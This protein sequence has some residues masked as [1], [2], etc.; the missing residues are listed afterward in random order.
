MSCRIRSVLCEISHD[1][2]TSQYDSAIMLKK[3]EF[4]PKNGTYQL[5]YPE[6]MAP[7]QAQKG[8]EKDLDQNTK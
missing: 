7:N 6:N 4:S 3:R 2:G 1:A 5:Q 8:S